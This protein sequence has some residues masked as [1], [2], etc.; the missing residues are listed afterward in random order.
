MTCY[1]P[2]QGFVSKYTTKS[3]KHK[4]TFNARNAL[5]YGFN[6]PVERI[7]PCNRCSGCR[8]QYSREWAIR[9]AHEAS[10]YEGGFNN[11]FLT[12]T[13]NDDYLPKVFDENGNVIGFGQL[14]YR[15]WQLFMKRLRKSLPNNKIRFYMGA[16]YGSLNYRP[17]FHALIFGYN[18]P[19]KKVLRE[20]RGNMLFTS[21]L[22]S[23][24]WSS[25]NGQ[26]FGYHSIG[27]V[28]FQSAAYCAR[29]M[30]KKAK[31]ELEIANRLERV[32]EYGEVYLLNQ[33]KALMSR[34]PGIAK[35]WFEKFA[36]SDLYNKD[37]VTL[38]SGLKVRAPKYYDKLLE[39]LDP[40]KLE[41]IRVARQDAMY[42]QRS[43]YTAERLAARYEVHLSQMRKLNRGF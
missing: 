7:L 35:E 9:C 43:E 22:V 25:K 12:L 28:T 5:G 11:A 10:L 37:F 40:Q 1:F 21:D 3:G 42:E 17:H 32:T 15:D 13:Y 30:M 39:E 8:L 14:D 20:V 29:Y 19:D 16:E 6:L 23:R 4:T 38:D 26:S 36:L 31:G 41:D 2:L 34:K 27:S 33:E 24:L 18:F